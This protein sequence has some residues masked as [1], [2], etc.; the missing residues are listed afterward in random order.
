MSRMSGAIPPL[1]Q[2]ASMAWCSVKSKGTTLSLPYYSLG[3]IIFLFPSTTPNLGNWRS[4]VKHPT[5][6][7]FQV[8]RA[9]KIQVHVFWGT[10]PRSFVVG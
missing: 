9:V 2:Y 8:F 1:P 4:V 10:T 6:K 7:R 3:A 5:N